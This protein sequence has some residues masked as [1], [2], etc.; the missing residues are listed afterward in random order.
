MTEETIPTEE[1]TKSEEPAIL[2]YCKTCQK[3]IL[4]PVKRGK[5]YDYTCPECKGDRVTFG[6]KNAIA[7]FYHIKENALEKMINPEKE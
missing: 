1:A 6:T 4:K 5:K 2:F 3:V 7:S